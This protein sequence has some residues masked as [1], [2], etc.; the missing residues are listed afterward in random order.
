SKSD[1][2]LE[3]QRIRHALSSLEALFTRGLPSA[4]NTQTEPVP[5]VSLGQPPSERP[6]QNAV[7]E[8]TTP[9]TLAT[10]TDRGFYAGP[11]SSATQLLGLKRNRGS[12]DSIPE[13]V[14]PGSPVSSLDEKGPEGELLDN[15][16]E[17]HVVDRLIEFYNDNCTWMNM[18]ILRST[19][20]NAWERF[21]STGKKSRV[22]MALISTVIAISIQFLPPRDP[23]FDSLRQEAI[24]SIA[25]LSDWYYEQGCRAL[26]LHESHTRLASLDLVELYLVQIFYLGI[27]KNHAEEIWRIRGCLISA[28]LALGLHRDPSKWQMQQAMAERRRWAW[29]NALRIE[30]WHAFMFGRPIAIANHHYDTAL[31]SSTDPSDPEAASSRDHLPFIH[32]FRLTEALGDIMDDLLS[33]KPVPYERITAHDKTLSQ[34]QDSFPAE[35]KLD[36]C[37]VKQALASDR[38]S[39]RRAGIQCL[40]L[41]L[42]GYHCQLAM[43]RPYA[44]INSV[45]NSSG[46][47]SSLQA[48][49]KAATMIIHLSSTTRHDFLGN[50]A[51]TVPGHI[52]WSVLHIFAAAMFLSFQA[53]TRP[54]QAGVQ[55]V[56]QNIQKSVATLDALR[57]IP[58]ADKAVTIV[59]ALTPLFED[60]TSS[61]NTTNSKRKRENVLRIVSGLPF[62][63]HDSPPPTVQ[64]SVHT[65]ARRSSSLSTTPPSMPRQLNANSILAGGPALPSTHLIHP[66]MNF[67]ATQGSPTVAATTYLQSPPSQQNA[68]QTRNS[69]MFDTQF[70]NPGD[71]SV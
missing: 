23:L 71:E 31:P 16:P 19:L 51:L 29:F 12:H 44:T 18:Y 26:V 1:P 8:K 48:A 63:Y 9:A 40:C 62:P 2:R 61:E 59:R 3:F 56:H 55:N 32:M 10:Q 27:S 4:S 28:A 42:V 50:P 21:K 34:W 11:T 20:R 70:L 13:V 69:S 30:R 15:L 17:W 33:V 68:Y 46:G 22:T 24:A 52:H 41:R 49:T 36:D 5:G 6:V 14:E 47:S 54:N 43:H 53:I 45:Q 57:G 64:K 58:A 7:D 37:D 39:V 38:L 66:Q 67:V 35:V 60:N 25:E 65:Q